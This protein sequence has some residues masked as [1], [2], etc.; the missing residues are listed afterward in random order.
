MRSSETICGRNISVGSLYLCD[1][2]C[3]LCRILVEAALRT[4]GTPVDAVNFLLE[5]FDEDTLLKKLAVVELEVCF[6]Y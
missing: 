3:S 5:N 2:L 1:I 4:R 6:V